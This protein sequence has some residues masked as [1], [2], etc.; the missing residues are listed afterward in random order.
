MASAVIKMPK[1][2]ENVGVVAKKEQ[3]DKTTPRKDA[4]DTRPCKLAD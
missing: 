2:E 1:Q 3:E 4:E